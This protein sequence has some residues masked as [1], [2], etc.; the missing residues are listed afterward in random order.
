MNSLIADATIVTACFYLKNY[1]PVSAQHLSR[2]INEMINLHGHFLLE[3]VAYMIIF[4]D[5]FTY[6]EIF[7]LRNERYQLGHLTKYHVMRF[8][9]IWAYQYKDKV[10]QNR[11]KYWLSGQGEID[12]SPWC[13]HL[14]QCNKF[15]F[16]QIALNENVFNTK[17]FIWSDFNIKKIF[18]DIRIKEKYDMKYSIDFRNS[19]FL[20]ILHNIP[21]KFKLFIIGVYDKKYIETDNLK[22]YYQSYPFIFSGILYSLSK[23]QKNIELLN[24]LKENFITTTLE[25]YG[26]GEEPLCLKVL[27]E[28]YDDFELTYGD[29]SETIYNWINPIDNHYYII[30][31]IIK[32]YLDFGY[33]RECYETCEKCLIAFLNS[34]IIIDYE[35]LM[36]LFFYKYVSSFYYKKEESLNIANTIIYYVENIPEFAMQFNKHKEFYLQQLSYVL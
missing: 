4:C 30:E 27:L 31:M 21:E 14:L 11:E 8:E 32:K 33:F 19:S 35:V 29:Y 5:E 25:G 36:Q 9:D 28:N 17:K 13:V 1:F 26:H 34:D 20:K 18:N 16:L 6:P 15:D 23:N 22:E 7:K 3:K 2:P 12:R 10:I 24:L